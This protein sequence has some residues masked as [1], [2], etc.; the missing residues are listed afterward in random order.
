MYDMDY[1]GIYVVIKVPD[2]IEERILG[3]PSTPNGYS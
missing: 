2:G 3:D 1:I